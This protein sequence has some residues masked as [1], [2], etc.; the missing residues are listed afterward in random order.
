[1]GLFQFTYSLADDWCHWQRTPSSFVINHKRVKLQFYLLT[2]QKPTDHLYC[3]KPPKVHKH[4]SGLPPTFHTM[5]MSMLCQNIWCIIIWSRCITK[6]CMPPEMT[7]Y[8]KFLLWYQ[9]LK[10][11]KLLTP[12]TCTKS[13]VRALALSSKRRPSAKEPPEAIQSPPD[14]LAFVLSMNFTVNKM[15]GIIKQN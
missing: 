2:H 10:S 4:S 1:M 13:P 11:L 6:K 5:Q 8:V 7:C 14:W 15:K 3:S 12:E 9:V